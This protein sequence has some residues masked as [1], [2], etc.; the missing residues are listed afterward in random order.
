MSIKVLAGDFPKSSASGA[1]A[2][3]SAVGG[4]TFT[5]PDPDADF[6]F[7]GKYVHYHMSRVTELEEVSEHN[8]VRVLGAAGWGAVGA[9]A[10]GPAGLLAGLI[11]GGRGKAVV[12]AVCFDDDRRALVQADQKTWTKIVAARF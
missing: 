9:L 10:L 11:L 5:F 8:K 2:T 6:S 7:F 1:M 3:F 4:G 12:F